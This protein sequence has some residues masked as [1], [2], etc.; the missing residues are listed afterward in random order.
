MKKENIFE[1][2]LKSRSKNINVLCEIG[3]K[4][5][6]SFVKKY[7]GIGSI[8]VNFLNMFEY[9]INS[10][11]V[12]RHVGKYTKLLFINFTNTLSGLENDI[13]PIISLCENKKIDLFI[14]GNV[15]S[16]TFRKIFKFFKSGILKNIKLYFY[17]SLNGRENIINNYN[18]LPKDSVLFLNSN[19][20]ENNSNIKYKELFLSKLNDFMNII[21]YDTWKKTYIE[22]HVNTTCL[23][24]LSSLQSNNFLS[25]SFISI[26]T[27][28]LSC[29]FK[30]CEFIYS[31][32]LSKPIY[33]IFTS[34]LSEFIKNGFII[35]DFSKI[36][37]IKS[38]G[39]IITFLFSEISKQNTTFKEEI[40]NKTK[41]IKPTSHK[42][43]VRFSTRL[44]INTALTKP[45]SSFYKNGR[46]KGILKKK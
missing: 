45:A 32:D 43:N 18:N 22:S 33:N 10:L 36:K 34:E 20:S 16:P 39:E 26:K 6:M 44:Y 3:D 46:L 7:D 4:K 30:P 14:N 28:I 41:K 37:T 31:T 13:I 5:I 11:V 35:I 40:I 38:I 12:D 2:A 24:F 42:K 23:Y 21:E 17:Y 9:R 27:K 29:K 8:N 1:D 25:I 19:I 15:I